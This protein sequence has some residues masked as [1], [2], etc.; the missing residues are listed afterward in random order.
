MKK[1]ILVFVTIMM[2]IA[3]SV[4]SDH[5]IYHMENAPFP[6]PQRAEGH[7]RKGIHYSYEEHYADS[8][9]LVIIPERY[10]KKTSVDLMLFFHGWGNSKDTCNKK[11]DLEKQLEASQKNMLLVIPEGPKFAPDSYNGKLCDEG[12]FKRFV[13]E[14]LDSLKADKII[15]S[16]KIGRIILSGHSG[17][18]YV[19]AHILRWGGYTDKISDVIVFDGLY[20]NED[21][22]FDWLLN[23]HGR[24]VDI[25][26]EHGGTKDN[27]ELFMARCDS[28]SIPYY[29]GE[30]NN[31][32]IMP[33]D[34]ILMLYSDLGHSDVMHKRQNVL[35]LLKR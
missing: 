9:V 8:S 21:D 30:T 4:P 11:F 18:Y 3:C 19:M 5:V 34:R 25:Y 12:G 27:S 35:K 26:T 6:H 23:Y 13:D 29:K 20:G 17:G 28:A 2:L 24:L 22:Y 1:Q 15:L 32:T 7:D 16:K 31:I 14:L 10:K 33:N